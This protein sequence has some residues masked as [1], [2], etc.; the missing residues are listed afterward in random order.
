MSVP[1]YG[2]WLLSAPSFHKLSHGFVIQVHGVEI[3]C[4]VKEV[5]TQF[6]FQRFRNGRVTPNRGLLHSKVP[7]RPSISHQ[8]GTIT[9]FLAGFVE[10]QIQ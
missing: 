8:L 6:L 10:V 5:K 4:A 9:A 3:D 2:A 7:A 1:K